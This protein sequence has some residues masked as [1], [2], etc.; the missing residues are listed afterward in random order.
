VNGYRDQRALQ[1]ACNG[2][3]YAWFKKIIKD[4]P[5]QAANA[6]G[7]LRRIEV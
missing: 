1:K 7:W 3:Q 2:E 5:S 6:R 4:D